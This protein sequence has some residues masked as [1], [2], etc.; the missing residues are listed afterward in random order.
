LSLSS[1]KPSVDLTLVKQFIDDTY[2]TLVKDTGITMMPGIGQMGGADIT[3]PLECPICGQ[4]VTD[5][6]MACPRTNHTERFHARCLIRWM[7]R[8]IAGQRVA[9]CPLCRADYTPEEQHIIRTSI[10]LNREQLTQ[11]SGHVQRVREIL[12]QFWL[13]YGPT[14]VFIMG[15][16]ILI[17]LFANP[18]VRAFAVC[19]LAI[20][21]SILLIVAWV[22]SIMDDDY[23]IG[24][25]DDNPFSDNQRGTNFISQ[26]CSGV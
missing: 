19:L 8:C 2:H 7:D 21:F 10:P 25:D 17:G 5:G 14:I 1:H 24:Y 3:P 11:W 4:P 20:M 9:N 23:Q 15:I 22:A 26:A 13:E 16:A 18:S 6:G 12:N